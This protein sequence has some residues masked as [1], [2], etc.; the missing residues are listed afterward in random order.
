M[1]GSLNST[2]RG[3][4]PVDETGRELCSDSNMVNQELKD[5]GSADAKQRRTLSKSWL[6]HSA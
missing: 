6:G 1:A 4:K 3:D 5:D 2:E